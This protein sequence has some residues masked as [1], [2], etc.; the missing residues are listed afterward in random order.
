MRTTHRIGPEFA[1]GL[2]VGLTVAGVT[3]LLAAALRRSRGRRHE[4]HP[5][6]LDLEPG[7]LERQILPPEESSACVEP[8]RLESEL[9]EFSPQSQRW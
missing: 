7:E 3:L 9:P 5:R 8:P 2:A 4:D 1:A 6:F